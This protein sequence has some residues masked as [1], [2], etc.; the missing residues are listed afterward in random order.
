MLVGNQYLTFLINLLHRKHLV[1]LW[2]LALGLNRA[3][4]EKCTVLVSFLEL[5]FR[6]LRVS[7][8]QWSLS[9]LSAMEELIRM[10][11]TGEPSWISNAENSTQTLC[12]E[13]YV[14]TSPRGIG[15]KPL[16]LKSEASQESAVVIMNHI[17]LVE[18]LMDVDQWT[19]VFDGQYQKQ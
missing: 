17:N 1:Q 2:I 11:K 9:L 3:C 15:L 19:S 14:Q 5:Q 4:L 8:S 18:I 12:E 10:A 6:A 16:A 7:R 13:E